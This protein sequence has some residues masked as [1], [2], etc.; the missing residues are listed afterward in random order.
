M[1]SE[2]EWIMKWMYDYGGLRGL[3]SK[4]P[5]FYEK[6]AV[7]FEGIDL[8]LIV[9]SDMLRL[10]ETDRGSPESSDTGAEISIC[11]PWG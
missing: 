5:D 4:G 2:W 10:T 11:C 8:H 6:H 1:V 3:Q 9:R 7:Y